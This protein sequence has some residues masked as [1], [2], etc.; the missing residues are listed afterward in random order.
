M[1][2]IPNNA[3]GCFGSALAFDPSTSFCNTC[4]FKGECEPAHA[5]NLIALRARLGVKIKDETTPRLVTTEPK[6]INPGLSAKAQALLDKVDEGGFNIVDS[7]KKGINPFREKFQFLRVAC[8]LL[9]NVQYPI[10]RDTLKMAFATKFNWADD[11]AAHHAR[12]VFQ[13]LE[14]VGVV[15]NNDGKIKLKRD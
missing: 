14:H 7:L 5:D 2:H 10:S 1:S 8:H 6:N 11:T 13:V 12:L 9:L 15:E 3:P 4:I